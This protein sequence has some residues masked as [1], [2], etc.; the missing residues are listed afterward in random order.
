MRSALMILIALVLTV[1]GGLVAQGPP[2]MPLTEKELVN[3]LKDKQFRAQAAAIVE[4]R[5]VAF[6]LDPEIEKK[7]RKAKAD[8]QLIEI[9][10]KATPT[11]RAE[12]A[13]AQGATVVTPEEG[14]AFQ[15]I[16][17]ELDPDRRLQ[18]A[19]DFEQKFPTSSLLTYVHV[20][21][22]RSYSEKNDLEKAIEA[23]EKS[24]QL[25]ND[26]LMTVLVAVDIL[27]Q[28]QSIRLGNAEEKLERAEKYAQRGLQLIDALA[29][30]PNETPEQ[31]A[32]RKASY[33]RDMHSALGMVHM[34]RAVLALQGPDR[35]EFE[36]AEQ[37]YQTAI[38]LT[39]EPNAADYFRLGEVRQNLGK[40]DAAIEAFSKSA[41]LG[42]PVIKQYA[43]ERIE[44]LQKVKA[45]AQPAAKPQ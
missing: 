41:A 32:A 36:Q 22:A 20:F 14:Q 40:I 23:C 18:L 44:E 5:G 30:G 8:D 9:V 25:K 6:E 13:K 15:L 10:K 16:Q 43:D 37:E 38:S 7:L 31:F 28:P 24:L 21:A 34:Q 19:A 27:P 2:A 33:Q 11:A 35:S 45:K 39:S 1:A 4:Q 3:I 17:N 42:D 29:A 26:N 12:R